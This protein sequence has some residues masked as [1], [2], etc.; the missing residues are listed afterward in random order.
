[1]EQKS[2]EFFLD[3]KTLKE[4]GNKKLEKFA[5]DELIDI[6]N[7]IK[8]IYSEA[9]RNGIK[10]K[11]KVTFKALE[12]DSF[13]IIVERDENNKKEIV[14]FPYNKI[15]YDFNE[16][17]LED[18]IGKILIYNNHDN[19]FTIDGVSL[20]LFSMSYKE[21]TELLCNISDR[22]GKSGYLKLDNTTI[23]KNFGIIINNDINSGNI[24]SISV[25]NRKEIDKELELYEK[26]TVKEVEEK[27]LILENKLSSRL[28]HLDDS[29]IDTDIEELTKLYEKQKEQQEILEKIIESKLEELKKINE[30]KKVDENDKKDEKITNE[31]EEISEN[32]LNS[33]NDVSGCK[34]YFIESYKGMKEYGKSDLCVFF[35]QSKDDIRAYFKSVPKQVNDFEEM[36][37]YDKFY[38]YYDEEDKC[39]GIGIYNKEEYKEEIAIYIFGKNII[40]MP[41]KEIVKLIK[42]HDYKAIEDE[43]GIISLEYG[44]SID[45]KDEKNYKDSICDVIHIFK[46]GYYD[47]VYNV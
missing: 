24:Y 6:D 36:E 29:K 28:K 18:F 16:I 27:E 2:N 21:A 17:I 44:I 20:N 32:L 42:D 5:K 8:I 37:M 47:E 43:D 34:S 10:D 23:Y 13:K 33:N 11:V 45:P 3:L 26:N 38:A 41:Y 9:E 39:T 12:N 14:V 46:K 35:G 19:F 15:K 31:M 4:K 22:K 1:M 7:V 40:D 30:T 25:C